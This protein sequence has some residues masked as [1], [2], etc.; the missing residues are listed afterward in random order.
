MPILKYR[1]SV[2]APWQVV[3][4]TG[5]TFCPQIVVTAPTESTVTCTKG[6]TVL[7]TEEVEGTWTFNVPEY[8]TW[9]VV[10]DGKITDSVVV[11]VVKQ[12]QGM[13]PL[14]QVIGYTMLYDYG[15]ECTDITGGWG[16]AVRTS[17]STVTKNANS[18]TLVASSNTSGASV[19]TKNKIPSNHSKFCAFFDVTST[20]AGE[21]KVILDLSSDIS[22]WQNIFS[23]HS[24]R[25]IYDYSEINVTHKDFAYGTITTDNHAVMTAY[26]PCTLNMYAYFLTK[27]DD[28]KTL[29]EKANITNHTELNELIND[30]TGIRD[31]LASRKT[32]YHMITQC[33][34][35][36]MISFISNSNCLSALESS[37]YKDMVYANEHWAKFLAMVQ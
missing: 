16:T 26:E 33:T 37:P 19:Y 9:D 5:P 25:V 28:W 17:S 8:G 2:G 32:V 18:I 34:G 21:N 27:E 12:Y 35:D 20:T 23:S 36:F 30:T 10:V 31:I 6:A 7:N 14:S 1:P 29:C 13:G 4:I 22:S 15:D 3:G 24:D 11:D